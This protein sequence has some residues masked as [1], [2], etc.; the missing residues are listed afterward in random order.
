[1]LNI[2]IPDDWIRTVHLWC[3]KQPLNTKPQPLPFDLDLV[4]SVHTNY[5]CPY[6]IKS[7]PVKLKTKHSVILPPTLSLLRV[8]LII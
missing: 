4:V 5:M 7:N 3:W 2:N 8:N 6:L 1:M